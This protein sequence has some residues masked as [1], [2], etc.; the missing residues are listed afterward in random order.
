[1]AID[2]LAQ[3]ARLP[4]QESLSCSP[5]SIAGLRIKRLSQHRICLDYPSMY[6]GLGMDLSLRGV[7]GWCDGCVHQHLLQSITCTPFF[8]A[9]A[10]ESRP[11]LI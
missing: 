2:V 7:T 4:C 1:M 11:P 9:G 8:S 3:L 10:H 5:N 6:C